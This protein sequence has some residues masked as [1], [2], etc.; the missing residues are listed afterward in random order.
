MSGV[1]GQRESVVCMVCFDIA[2]AAIPHQTITRAAAEWAWRHPH[3][4]QTSI[5]QKCFIPLV[6]DDSSDVLS[7]VHHLLTPSPS[8]QER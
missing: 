3:T 5:T 7:P 1:V 6:D 2:W 8:A 4:A